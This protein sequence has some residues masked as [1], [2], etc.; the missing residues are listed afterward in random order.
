MMYS[1]EMRSKHVWDSE[2]QPALLHTSCSFLFLGR[3]CRLCRPRWSLKSC[4]DSAELLSLPRDA[5][6]K[7]R[8]R[9]CH[10]A[11]LTSLLSNS[12]PPDFFFRL[13][14]WSCQVIRF[15]VSPLRCHHS[16]HTSCFLY[17]HH[18]Q[19]SAKRLSE[20]ST[21]SRMY[22]TVT[23]QVE[24]SQQVVDGTS[25]TILEESMVMV[26]G[27]LHHRTDLRTP[28]W[29]DRSG[30]LAGDMS[31]ERSLVREGDARVGWRM[32]VT[33]EIGEKKT[34]ILWER[35]E[36]RMWERRFPQ[37]HSVTA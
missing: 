19:Y 2:T 26:D 32:E 29:W 4:R 24:W 31:A 37:W 23:D 28:R 14:T 10:R 27:G 15:H 7:Q 30:W 11:A 17:P 9:V 13:Q 6:F 34:E 12:S 1:S 21:D 16:L 3:T 33:D 36:G 25:W 22:W 18:M 8:W 20:S 35:D 5:G